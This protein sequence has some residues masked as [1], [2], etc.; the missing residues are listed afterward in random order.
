M[1]ATLLNL[2]KIGQRYG[3]FDLAL[4]ECRQYNQP[5]IHLALGQPAQAAADLR[6]RLL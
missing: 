1:V 2:K 4:L 3:P 5:Y 6:T